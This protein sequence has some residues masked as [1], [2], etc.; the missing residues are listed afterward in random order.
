VPPPVPCCQPRLRISVSPGVT[1]IVGNK[2]DAVLFLAAVV[3]WINA[4]EEMG[5]AV[6]SGVGVPVEPG[7]GVGEG[8][9]DGVTLGVGDGE[10]EGVTV[11]VGVA[12]AVG[13]G[14]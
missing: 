3:C 13:V 5:V 10:G 1:V 7:V 9:A 8:V 2:S 14:V 6:G 12:E 11:A 4:S